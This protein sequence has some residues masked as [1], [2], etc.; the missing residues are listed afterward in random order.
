[1]TRK[2]TDILLGHD[3]PRSLLYKCDMGDNENMLTEPRH[4]CEKSPLLSLQGE[5]KTELL[6]RM[7]EEQTYKS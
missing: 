4:I 6:K 3:L 1:M 5:T 2:Q 7:K